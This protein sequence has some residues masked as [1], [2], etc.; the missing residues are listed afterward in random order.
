MSLCSAPKF[1]N[2]FLLY[3][4]QLYLCFRFLE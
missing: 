1:G 2:L 3:M 4:F